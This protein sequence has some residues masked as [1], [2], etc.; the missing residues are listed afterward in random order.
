MVSL[1]SKRW[2]I[3]AAIIGA[4][5]VIALGAAATVV[6]LRLVQQS[7]QEPAYTKARDAGELETRIVKTLTEQ[8]AALRRKDEKAFLKPAKDQEIRDKLKLRYDN[9]IALKVTKFTLGLRF[10]SISPTPDRWQ[11]ELVVSFCFVLSDC[12][13]DKIYEPTL[14]TETSKGPELVSL[15]PAKA[16]DNWFGEP[17]PWETTKLKVAQR[18]RVLVAAP[19]S[20]ESRLDLVL[21]AAVAAVPVADA[22]AVGPP[23]DLYR[24]YLA[25]PDG[26]KSWYGRQ[27]PDWSAGYAIPIGAT[28]SDVVLNNEHNRSSNLPRMLRHE[29]THAST[30]QGVH[31]WAGNWWLL[32]GIAEVAGYAEGESPVDD[33]LRRFIRTGWDKKLDADGPAESATTEDAGRAYSIAFLAVKRLETRFGRAK[34]ITFFERV[35]EFG[36]DYDKASTT[37]FGQAWAGVESDVLS[38]IRSA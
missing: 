28:H 9:L 34:L 5:L 29:L 13:A 16:D 19:E 3:P 15:E 17:Q 1:R 14:W 30:I 18:G 6:V 35:V 10:L 38:A 21:D 22:F 11:A 4:V 7:S 12:V 2:L 8:A 23:P 20:L 32:E 31:Q 36:E 33:D 25:Y 24:V 37:A 27:P 26:W